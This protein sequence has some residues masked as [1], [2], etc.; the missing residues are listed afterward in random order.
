MTIISE[1][2][3]VKRSSRVTRIVVEDKKPVTTTRQTQ[4]KT[5]Q[6]RVVIHGL[7]PLDEE[8]L[9]SKS[10]FSLPSKHCW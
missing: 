7:D 10:A 4:M 3:D 1:L 5:T 8:Y 2:V 6:V 9:N